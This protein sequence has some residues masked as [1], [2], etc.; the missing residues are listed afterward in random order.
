MV[1]TV[2][3]IPGVPAKLCLL[4]DF[5]NRP[6]PDIISS[7][8]KNRPDLI[9]IAGDVFYSTYPLVNQVYVPPFLEGCA[10]IAP[11]YLSL[12]NHEQAITELEIKAIESTGVKVLDNSW[13]EKDG[14][15]IGG[16][17]SGYVTAY[18]AWRATHPDAEKPAH[19]EITSHNPDTSWLDEFADVPGYHILLSHHPSYFSFVPKSIELALGGH[20]HGSQWRYY[21]IFK[22][23]WRGVFNPD[24][25]FF[26]RYSKG[27]YEN[28]RL[29]ISAGLTN[30]APVPR[31]FN[32]TEVVYIE[33]P[34]Q[35]KNHPRNWRY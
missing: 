25:G 26:P 23:E 11:T 9:L 8:Q 35:P 14:L 33:K 20:L 12:G 30:T 32:P 31:F 1:E 16:L 2:Y 15:V 5:H 17:S 28:G 34:D 27:K 3:R 22:H 4:A 19:G 10:K 13:V 29:I 21:S 7:L 6:N 18:R 24:E